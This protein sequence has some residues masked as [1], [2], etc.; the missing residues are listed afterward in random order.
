MYG[1]S[2]LSHNWLA[3]RLVNNQVR[4]RLPA[5][6]GTVLDLGCGVRPFEHDILKHADHY[7]GIDWNNTLHGLN[8]DV[9]ADLNRGLPILSGSVDHVVSFEVAEHLREPDII[10]CEAI[11][12]LKSGG[13]LT[14]SMPFQWWVHEA[15]WDYQRFTRYGI[16]YH[17]QKGGFVDI[18]VTPIS[19]FWS[20]WTLKLN[21]QLRRLVRGSALRRAMTSCLLVPFWWTNQTIAP[22]LDR[23]WHEDRETAGYFVTARKP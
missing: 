14:M 21:Y 23:I 22:R 12:V 19:G 5:L 8:A 20:M 10:F 6:S 7:I 18:T 1:E 15:P 9:I 3:K 4:Q 2:L 11:R 16:E 17:L 13:G